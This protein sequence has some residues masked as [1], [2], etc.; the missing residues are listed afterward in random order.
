MTSARLIQEE[1]DS[2]RSTRCHALMVTLT[3]RQDDDW[4]PLQITAYLKRVRQY[5]LRRSVLIRYIWVHELTKAGKTHYH[6]LFWL[7]R[8]YQMPK[9]DKRG[10]W[11]HGM[12]K[13]EKVRK[14][15]IAYV[16]KYASKGTHDDLPK[17]AR[18]CGS[19]GLS[20]DARDQRAWWGCPGYVRAW[21]PDYS[22]RPRRAEGGGW[23]AKSSGDYLPAL[24]ELVRC[25]PL[26]VRRKPLDAPPDD[27]LALA[28]C[29][30]IQTRQLYSGFTL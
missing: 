16:A 13:T 1:V 23:I 8:C 10:W 27:W 15:A 12:T 30:C 6:V 9:A 22:D 25:F 2:D 3:Y 20:A 26:M 19:G 7:P 21:C 29:S 17:G 4:C 5:F 14:N 11:P 18:L 24:F 28:A